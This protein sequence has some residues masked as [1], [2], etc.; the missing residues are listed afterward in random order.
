M[1]LDLLQG[2]VL[3][4]DTGEVAVVEHDVYA[5]QP[6]EPPGG[7][8]PATPSALPQFNIGEDLSAGLCEQVAG[9]LHTHQRGVA[10][11]LA[12]GPLE[13]SGHTRAGRRLLAAGLPLLPRPGIRAPYGLALPAPSR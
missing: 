2:A 10:D 8:S 11:Q 3:G 5:T 6:L 1:E 7:E 13:L 4:D 12:P 9:D